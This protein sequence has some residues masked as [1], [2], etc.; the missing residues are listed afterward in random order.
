MS[1]IVIRAL[2][3]VEEIA[4]AEQIQRVAWTMSDLDII[5]THA[6]HAMEHNGAVLLARSR[7]TG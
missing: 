7:M 2:E 4:Q 3:T 6:L 5:P 1:E